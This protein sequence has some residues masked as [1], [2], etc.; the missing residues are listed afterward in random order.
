[1]QQSE[2]RN[3]LERPQWWGE[4]EHRMTK[5]RAESSAEERGPGSE[6]VSEEG[7][8]PRNHE[9]GPLEAQG[10]ERDPG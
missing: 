5:N 8:R 1:M 7:T 3:Q 6:Y 4:Q 2:Q 9:A 10:A